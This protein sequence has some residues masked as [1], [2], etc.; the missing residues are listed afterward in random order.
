MAKD[1]IWFRSRAK[2]RPPAR[3][4]VARRPRGSEI[5]E[6][7]DYWRERAR[8]PLA[9]GGRSFWTERMLYGNALAGG[10]FLAVIEIWK[11]GFSVLGFI[12]A[13]LN[14]LFLAFIWYYAV[15]WL[16]SAIH[17]GMSPHLRPPDTAGLKNELIAYSGIF[18]LAPLLA[19]ASFSL[20]FWVGWILIAAILWRMLRFYYDE[21]LAASALG[22]LAAS[23]LMA[24]VAVFFFR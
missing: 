20:A 21:G 6:W 9:L 22:T 1:P 3:R 14:V 12:S 2:K 13:V 10:L 5:D 16:T 18:A 11:I 17:G 15:P 19:I 23:G 8:R 24:L 4:P 7:L